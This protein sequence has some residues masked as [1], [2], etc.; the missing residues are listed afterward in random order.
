M[1]LAEI[2][3]R[4]KDQCPDFAH[5]DHV[6]TSPVTHAYPAALIVPV[7]KQ[8]SPPRINIPGGFSQDVT[9]IVGVY[10]V[11]ERRQNG[12][13]DYTGADLFD[14]LCA[15]LQ[16]ALV[17]W[18]PTGAIQPMFY[19]GGKMAPYDAGVITWRED[20]SVDYEVRYP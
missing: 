10:I 16:A 3:E 14:T 13:A 2:V 20:F 12:I 11:L 5:I 1:T 15:Q 18:T 8:A 6:L 9:L 17:N 4:I 7:D 19:A